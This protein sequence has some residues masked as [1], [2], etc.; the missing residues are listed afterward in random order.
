MAKYLIHTYPNRMWYVR[1]YLV[2]SMRNQGITDI[3]VECDKSNIGNLKSCMKI[4]SMMPD[5]DEGCWHLQDDIV[6]CHDFKERT[7]EHDSGVVAG[8][9]YAKSNMDGEVN[10]QHIWYSFPCIRIPNRIAREC[11]KWFYANK[12]NPEYIDRSSVNKYDD[13]FFREFLINKYPLMNVL[14]L[15]PNLVD[16]VDYLIGGSS[17]NKQRKSKQTRARYFEDVYLVDELENKL[18]G[19]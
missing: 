9:V 3:S 7:E 6:I 15:K 18:R 10:V 14:N 2:P 11:A 1:R 17:V 16:H 12:D 4:F 5:D 13:W 19:Q 8:Y